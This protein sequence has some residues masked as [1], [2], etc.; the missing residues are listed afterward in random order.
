MAG[1]PSSGCQPTGSS[2]P[3]TWAM[4]SALFG[5]TGPPLNTTDGLVASSVH[6][7][8]TWPTGTLVGRFSTT[9]SV[10]CSDS[11]STIRTTVR[12]KLGS[13]STGV[14]TSRRPARTSD[15]ISSMYLSFRPLGR[16]VPDRDRDCDRRGDVG[17]EHRGDDVVRPDL[18]R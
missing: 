15:A 4:A 1:A 6:G 12:R 16:G 3:D 18:V 8:S 5:A 9:P 7:S 10:P 11:C 13:P 2:V 14:A 17:V